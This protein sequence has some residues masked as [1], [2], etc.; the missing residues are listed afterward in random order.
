MNL[1]IT[2]SGR[3][4]GNCK[5]IA[6][7]IAHPE[8]RIVDFKKLKVHACSEC[9][10]DCFKGVC[11]YRADD[12]YALFDGMLQY[13]KVILIVPMYCAN[14]SSLYFVFNERSQDYFRHNEDNYDAIVSR[15]YFIG[16]YGSA[17]ETPDFLPVF[18]KWFE[19]EDPKTH[20]LGI[21][22]RRYNQK[23]KDS[24]V[25]EEEVQRML[26]KFMTA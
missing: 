10:Y 8:D 13:E 22:R 16:V 23:M 15:M 6:E 3:D 20:V 21:E 14:P 4:S 2:F 11:R 7:F 26:R 25:D 12:M 5:D 17:K 19:N 18:E 1:I 24:V 9:A